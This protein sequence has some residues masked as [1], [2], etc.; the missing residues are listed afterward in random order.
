MGNGIIRS[1]PETEKGI[2]YL[3]GLEKTGQYV[4][5]GSPDGDIDILTPR[6]AHHVPDISKPSEK[7][8]D[9]LPS[10]SATPYADFAVF[11]ALVNKKNLPGGLSGFGFKDKVKEF[12]LSNKKQVELLSDKVGYVYVFNKSDFEP[13]SRS[14]V[15]Q[16]TYMEWRAYSEVKPIEVVNVTFKDLEHLIPLIQFTE[17]GK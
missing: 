8:E 1:K 10:V 15:K 7:I 13:Y 4:F 3:N 12:R 16:E 17:E 5:H 2:D 9:G 6:Q 11:R 14:G